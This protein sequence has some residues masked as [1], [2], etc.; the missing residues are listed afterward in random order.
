M[1]STIKCFNGSSDQVDQSALFYLWRKCRVQAVELDGDGRLARVNV[2]WDDLHDRDNEWIDANSNRLQLTGLSRHPSMSSPN[3]TTALKPTPPTAPTAITADKEAQSNGAVKPP[4]TDA[5]PAPPA[6]SDADM[7][8]FLANVNDNLSASSST[9]AATHGAASSPTSSQAAASIAAQGVDTAF[10]ASPAAP[11]SSASL[12]SSSSSAITS[13]NSLSRSRPPP[14]PPG[15]PPK[16][17]ATRPNASISPPPA[18]SPSTSPPPTR[19][20][21][22]PAS[23]S[24]ATSSADHTAPV[25]SA[26]PAAAAVP[27]PSV[28]AGPPHWEAGQSAPLSFDEFSAL[29]RMDPDR[30]QIYQQQWHGDQQTHIIASASSTAQPPPPPPP[31]H[32]SMSANHTTHPTPSSLPV[33][34]QLS[35]SSSA[36]THSAPASR[37]TSRKSSADGLSNPAPPATAPP[38]AVPEQLSEFARDLARG[39][40]VDVW[41]RKLGMWSN[42]EV[43]DVSQSAEKG[44]MVNLLDINTNQREWIRRASPRIAP[45]FTKSQEAAPSPPPT[46]KL[47]SQGVQAGP[48]R[49]TGGG[50]VDE[51][52]SMQKVGAALS[53]LS[54]QGSAAL[55][56]MAAAL[57]PTSAGSPRSSSANGEVAHQHGFLS[58]KAHKP[59]PANQPAYSFA[60]PTVVS[61]PTHTSSHPPAVAS[62]SAIIASSSSTSSSVPSSSS[63][64]SSSSSSSSAPPA[65]SSSHPPAQASH[66]P[67]AAAVA[68]ASLPEQ[69]AGFAKTL[70]TGSSIDCYDTDQVWRMAEVTRETAEAVFVHYIGWTSK[71]DEWIARTNPRIQPPRSHA[72]GDTG[73]KKQPPPVEQPIAQ[74]VHAYQPHPPASA[75]AA[76]SQQRAPSARYECRRDCKWKRVLSMGL[77]HREIQSLDVLFDRCC[78]LQDDYQEILL[79]TD[80]TKATL[81][82]FHTKSTAVNDDITRLRRTLPP[83]AAFYLQQCGNIV[84]TVQSG[85]AEAEEALRRQMLAM[86]EEMYMRRLRKVF[87]LV[88]VPADGDCLFTAVGKGYAKAYEMEMQQ[89]QQQQQQQ[90]QQATEKMQTKQPPPVPSASATPVV[91]SAQG[92]SA[93]SESSTTPAT[94]ALAVLPVADAAASHAESS[95]AQSAAAEASTGKEERNEQVAPAAAPANEQF[96]PQPADSFTLTDTATS[97][98]STTDLTPTPTPTTTTPQQP[99]PPPPTL[100][101]RSLARH[102]RTTAI[103]QLLHT[104]SFHPLVAHEVKEALIQEREGHSDT[105]S[106]AIVGVLNERADS[107]GLALEAAAEGVKAEDGLAVYCDVMARDGIYGT[108]LEVQALSQAL[109]VPVHVYFRAGSAD[110]EPVGGGEEEVKPTQIIGAEEKGV[111]IS[112]AYYMGNRHYNLLLPRPPPPPPAPAPPLPPPA[113]E[114]PAEQGDNEL[115]ALLRNGAP[116]PPPAAVAQSDAAA[117]NLQMRRSLSGGHI[118]G[119]AQ[120]SATDSAAA[121]GAGMHRHSGSKDELHLLSALS[122]SKGKPLPL[123]PAKPISQPQPPTQPP[124]PPHTTTTTTTHSRPPPAHAPPP[125][126]MHLPLL[127]VHVVH[128]HTSPLPVSVSLARNRPLLNVLYD[129]PTAASSTVRREKDGSHLVLDRTPDDYQLQDGETLTLFEPGEEPKRQRLNS[130]ERAAAPSAAVVGT[131]A[132]SA[133]AAAAAPLS[134]ED[135]VLVKSVVD[136]IV[137]AV[138]SRAPD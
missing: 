138:V 17:P 82:A 8:S 55:S 46:P 48:R 90:Q 85:I 47:A 62:T 4:A 107:G 92:S 132:S 10:F 89:R 122:G 34:L 27:H 56:T 111:P 74:P 22:L 54:Q 13:T 59:L 94:E 6:L 53:N 61:L 38:A 66:P 116:L 114:K 26:P 58:P 75:A 101:G 129:F 73:P 12:S 80:P 77:G 105:T 123:P 67:P 24:L 21:S 19:A 65:P 60:A 119:S 115:V 83:F 45:P 81:A 71:W 125:H 93:Q 41:N 16:L 44:A 3:S 112:L 121:A 100:S 49:G 68:P 108:Q 7:S 52:S 37:N 88:E 50:M 14:L 42:G 72:S 33:T 102:Y 96:T 28:V 118:V 136:G 98:A 135:S 110:D 11:H 69:P 32:S 130:A 113:V 40:L 76:V 79:S 2:S 131:Q 18:V 39:S 1:G 78:Q 95:E 86:Q 99:P 137:N 43:V 5:A 104:P 70:T 51:R 134:A 23:Q 15:N 127:H 9:S 64:S 103:N 87:Q 128:P 57:L 20:A 124:H 106:K 109:H 133:A 97:T 31:P 126:E 91:T 30:Y 120:P 84:S 29:Y 25:S 35:S 117:N 36:S 63:L